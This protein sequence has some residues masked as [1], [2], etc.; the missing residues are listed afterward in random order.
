MKD[1][2]VDTEGFNQYYEELNRLK[3]ISLSIASIGSESYADAVGDGWHDNFAFE[4]TMRES[5]KIAS[6]INK[7]L[8]DEKYLKIVDKKSNSDDIIDIGDI[9]KIKVIYDIDDIEEYTIK[10]TGKYMIDNNA[11][12]KEISLNSPIGRSIYLK[13]INDNDICYYVNDK[14]IY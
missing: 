12:I 11:K 5:R 4:D 7:M 10:L 2:L 14:K 9:L 1:V 6:R 8:D 13:S 3:D